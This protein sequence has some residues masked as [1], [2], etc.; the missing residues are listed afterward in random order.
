VAISWSLASDDARILA[1]A[2]NIVNRANSIAREQG[3]DF[4]YIYQNYAGQEQKVFP[5]YG[6][7]NLAK[8]KATSKKYDPSGVF[9]KLQPGYFKLFY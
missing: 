8:L 5:S 1:A 7:A 2:R 6:S 9:Q 4:P 3:L